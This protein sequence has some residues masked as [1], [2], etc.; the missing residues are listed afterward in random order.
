MTGA[1]VAGGARRPVPGAVGAEQM[2]PPVTVPGATPEPQRLSVVR[3]VGQPTG[4]VAGRS[5]EKVSARTGRTT[6]F[7]NPDGTKTL[8]V[9]DGPA[10]VRDGVGQWTPID[11]R[12]S[13]RRDGRYAPAAAADVTV[14]P[15]GDDAQVATLS[16]GED[17][18]IS[19]AV[20]GAAAVTP[21]VM[22][23]TATFAAVRPASDV[24]LTP[25][26][27]GL[28]EEIVLHSAD[29][30]TSW[31][32]PLIVK[33]LTPS[34][35]GATGEVM[36]TDSAGIV[37][38]V[39]PP[40]FMVDS[41]VHPRRG[42]GERSDTVR[43]SLQRQG[44]GWV[45]RVDLDE[46]WLRDPARVF[47]V[48]VDPSFT[49]NSE[50]DDTFVS[51]RDHANRNNSAESDLLAGTYNGGAER[52]ASYLHFNDL[53]ASR[54]NRYVLGATLRLWNFWS[55][56]CRARA[57][58][59][60]AVTKSWSGSST[61]TW[62]GPSFDSASRVGTGSFAY[63]YYDCP[64]GG[65]AGFSLPPDRVMKWLHGTEAFYGLTV[66]ASETDSFAWKRFASANFSNSTA[67]PYIDLSYS[68][69]GAKYS[70]PSPTFNPPVTAAS[71]GMIT[72]RVTNWGMT[73]WTPTNGYRLTYK[74][75]NSSGSVIRSGRRV[76]SVV[77]LDLGGS[78]GQD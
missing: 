24:K 46:Q 77:A 69:Q 5:V 52:A 48:I 23:S 15:R 64:S 13:Q 56:S 41:N 26:E 38:A 50:T 73:T 66:R 58:N 47:P 76:Q 53:K 39:I 71:A 20:A 57:V 72:A 31:T 6:E 9:F 37:R 10:F 61:T 18:S 70:L 75:L 32:F 78:V 45:L 35:N 63:G 42:S 29:A 59:V 54:P 34:M 74:I 65:W 55:Y 21:A 8:R 44:G 3:E 1:A 28:K 67:R 30:P 14:A 27:W 68:D 51:K 60:Y 7:D 17:A 4:F 11:N 33:G 62:A 2:F 36:F 22:D 19:F 43:Y 40:G 16:L 25:M 49:D 12:L